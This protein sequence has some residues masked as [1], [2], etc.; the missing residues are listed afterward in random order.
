M[1]ICSDYSTGI[2]EIEQLARNQEVEVLKDYAQ[3]REEFPILEA[4]EII[5]LLARIRLR[6]RFMKTLDGKLEK[7]LLKALKKV[8][9]EVL[10]P[11]PS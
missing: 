4:S 1:T 7:P 9:F 2:L 8:F 10:F 6:S 3:S 11:T 5:E